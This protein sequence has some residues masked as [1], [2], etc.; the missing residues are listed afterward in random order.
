MSRVQSI[1]RAFAVKIELA[2]IGLQKVDLTAVVLRR[3]DA[4]ECALRG[5]VLAG[6]NLFDNGVPVR[7][8]KRVSP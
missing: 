3:F 4:F 7:M 6:V 2:K 5:V 1:E 8:S